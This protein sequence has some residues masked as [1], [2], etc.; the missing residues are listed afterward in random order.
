MHL[1]KCGA[2]APSKRESPQSFQQ[3][4]DVDAERKCAGGLRKKTM[5]NDVKQEAE[6]APSAVLGPET[7]GKRLEN[8]TRKTV[9]RS[10]SRGLRKVKAF[11]HCG[12]KMS[13][14]RSLQYS[15]RSTNKC[16]DVAL[17]I[18]FESTKLQLDS[19][20]RLLESSPQTKFAKMDLHGAIQDKEREQMH[21]LPS[22]KDRCR[23][24]NRSTRIGNEGSLPLSKVV[25]LRLVTHPLRLICFFQVLTL[26]IW[27]DDTL[28]CNSA[29]QSHWQIIL[30]QCATSTR[31]KQGSTLAD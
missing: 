4:K 26:Y 10:V 29:F 15:N 6:K 12:Q 21:M 7:S 5:I 31:T 8:S 3:I 11:F 13:D 25:C 14:A 30:M 17:C 24:M 28:F 9:S 18:N 16:G 20:R 2:V 1:S 27:N 22:M 23:A 19:W